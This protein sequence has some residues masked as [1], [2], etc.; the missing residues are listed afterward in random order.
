VPNFNPYNGRIFLELNQ[1]LIKSNPTEYG[2][3]YQAH[4]LEIYKTYL[5]MADRI[6]ARRQQAN[7]FFLTI[8]SAIIA[9]LG[10]VQFGVYLGAKLGVDQAQTN[11]FYWIISLLGMI[12]C[13]I[14]FRLILSYKQL[15]TAKFLVIQ[16][17][18]QQLPLAP[19]DAE[20]EAVGK[21]KDPKLYKP[22]THVEMAIP[23]VFFLLNLAVFLRITFGILF[24]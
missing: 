3:N 5:E 22:F 11:E 2:S 14:W 24:G 10:Y 12:L 4:C 6:S 7:S 1:I 16:H 23:W 18:E 13:Y 20:W 21:G 17:I 9:I 19:Y 8:N 15:N